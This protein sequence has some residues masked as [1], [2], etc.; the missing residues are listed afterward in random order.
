VLL[1]NG[2][3]AEGRPLLLALAQV[4][5]DGINDLVAAALLGEVT[6]NLS[7]NLFLLIATQ[8][9]EIFQEGIVQ[10][11]ARHVFLSKGIII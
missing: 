11:T 6:C 4:L 10:R 5:L 2:V 3:F 7:L 1:E 8:I 9:I